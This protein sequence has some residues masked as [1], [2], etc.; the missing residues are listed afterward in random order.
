MTWR[1]QKKGL[2][3]LEAP[4]IIENLNFRIGGRKKVATLEQALWNGQLKLTRPVA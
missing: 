4:V 3:K 2:Q 1:I